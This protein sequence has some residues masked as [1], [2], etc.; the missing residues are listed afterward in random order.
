MCCSARPRSRRRVR[1]PPEQTPSVS[2][3]VWLLS[4]EM[5]GVQG[6]VAWCFKKCQVMF[7]SCAVVAFGSVQYQV[8]ALLGI[9]S[10]HACFSRP[11]CWWF[12][13]DWRLMMVTK[14]MWMVDDGWW[15]HHRFWWLVISYVLVNASCSVSDDSILWWKTVA[16]GLHCGWCG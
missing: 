5:D 1:R 7:G 13:L 15:K 2:C 3:K 6:N 9:W 14:L 8:A 11:T 4:A 10:S 12:D 16:T